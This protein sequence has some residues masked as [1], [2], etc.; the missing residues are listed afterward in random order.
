MHICIYHPELPEF[1]TSWD[2][3]SLFEVHIGIVLIRPDGEIEG[4][5]RLQCTSTVRRKVVRCTHAATEILRT[6]ICRDCVTSF[7]P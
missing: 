2:L 6:P 4:D 5:T 3:R 7:V 1:L